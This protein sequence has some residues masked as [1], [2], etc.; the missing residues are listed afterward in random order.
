MSS[1]E[2]RIGAG[3][4]LSLLLT[5]LALAGLAEWGVAR[6]SQAFVATR[7]EHDADNLIRALELA[8]DGGWRLQETQVP[9]IYQRVHS[10]HYF[11]I[12]GERQRLRS[13]SLWDR[14]PDVSL[15]A[16]GASRLEALYRGTEHWL[17]WHQG[18]EW[19]GQRLTLWLAEDLTPLESQW[20][21]FAWGLY[22]VMA[23]ALVGQL[24]LQRH[25]LR[26]SFRQLE[27]VRRAVGKLQQGE[28]ARLEE[29][30][31][32]EIQPLT[33]EIN[34]LLARLEQQIGRARTTMGNLAHELKRSLQ[35][36][37]LQTEQLPPVE[38]EPYQRLLG[39][40]E[41][42]TERELRRA[43]IA[44][45]PHP[46]RHF[47]PAED[48]PHLVSVL[49]RIY[50][51]IGIET[52]LGGVGSLP[53]DRDDMLELIG[54]LLD[55]GCKFARSRVGLALERKQAELRLC[56]SDDGPGIAGSDREALTGRGRRLDET[57]AGH[58]LGLSICRMIVDSYGG[59]LG[60]DAALCS[61]FPGLAV[62]ARL[63]L[64]GAS[65][66]TSPGV[67]G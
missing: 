2:R 37:Q 19:Q 11:Q 15:L 18:I 61:E 63:P 50:P 14:A 62:E 24:A 60:F 23:L 28:I 45:T 39:E 35:Q 41:R 27:G 57:V 30:V 58:G 32:R 13:R 56:I 52:R 21:R 26:R 3:L 46:G 67:S 51:A 65:P 5:F 29:R 36:L 7:L 34:R 53:L 9:P 8:P 38:R 25:L 49:E 6:L 33:A 10:G 17:T 43:R 1:I 40:V 47:D 59:T 22:A 4:A 16:P 64:P 48:L 44:G 55:N 31:P 12:R 66:G 20:R 42:L 54:N